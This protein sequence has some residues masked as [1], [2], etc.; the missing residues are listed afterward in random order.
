MHNVTETGPSGKLPKTFGIGAAAPQPPVCLFSKQV[1]NTKVWLCQEFFVAM[2][3]ISDN[4][5]T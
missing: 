3:L 4:F 1:I 5:T 2:L